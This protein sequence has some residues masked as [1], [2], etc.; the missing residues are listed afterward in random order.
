MYTRSIA[1]I[2]YNNTHIYTYIYIRTHIHVHVIGLKHPRLESKEN[3]GMLDEFVTAV[4]TRW[5]NVVLQ[6]E[7]CV[8]YT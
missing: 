7:V 6:F 1:Y 2:I 5:P 3:V 4:F 8:Y